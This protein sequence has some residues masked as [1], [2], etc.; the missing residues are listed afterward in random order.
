MHDTDM[1]SP[2]KKR[3]LII[4]GSRT[5]V[6]VEDAFWSG[7]REIANLQGVSLSQLTSTV[8]AERQ[9]ANL[10]SAIRLYVLGHYRDRGEIT[11]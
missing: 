8:N 1:K 11:D 2:V 10:S 4:N 3:S 9:T 6:S 5:S 7:L